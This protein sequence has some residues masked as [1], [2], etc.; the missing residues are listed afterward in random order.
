MNTKI[1]PIFPLD[2]VVFPQQVLPLRIF[3]PRYKQLIDD[4]ILSEREFGICLIDLDKT[5]RGWDAPKSIGTMV[6][7]TKCQDVELGMQYL[8][9]TV[10]RKKF[11][12]EKIIPPSLELPANYDP[13][14]EE[15]HRKILELNEKSGTHDKMYVSAKVSILPEIEESVSI[16]KWEKIVELWKSRIIY[17]ALPQIVN[18]FELDQVLTQYCLTD[19]PTVNNIYSLAT[20]GIKNPHELQPILE[21]NSLSELY[22]RTEKLFSVK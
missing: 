15:G 19:L 13:Y 11:K 10:G 5:I 21:A 12:I 8:V 6:K 4:A 3:E 17:Q 7:I 18:P 22:L 1:L 9:E 14:T 2:I 16:E 20:L